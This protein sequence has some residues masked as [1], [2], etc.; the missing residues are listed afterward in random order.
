MKQTEPRKNLALILPD[1]ITLRNFVFSTFLQR[2]EELFAITIYH[3]PSAD[4]FAALPESLRAQIRF[5]QISTY[6][7]NPLAKAFRYAKQKASLKRNNSQNP[8]PT[9]LRNYPDYKKYPLHERLVF[10]LANFCALSTSAKW[11]YWLERA[12][13]TLF[14]FFHAKQIAAYARQFTA[15]Q[16]SVVLNAHQRDVKSLPMMRAAASKHIP[17]INFI[18]S[19]DNLPKGRMAVPASH[20]FVWSKYMK[21]EMNLYYPDIADKRI[22]I[23]GT[24]QFEFYH[25][26]V[27]HTKEQFAQTYSLDLSK[28]WIIYT[29]DMTDASPFDQ[30]YLEDVYSAWKNSR[31]YKQSQLLFRRAPTDLTGRFD[32]VLQRCP[33][34]VE[35]PTLWDTDGGHQMGLRVTK[36]DVQ[37][38]VDL[39]E[40]CHTAVNFGSTMAHDFAQRNKRIYYLNYNHQNVKKSIWSAEIFYSYVHFESLKGLDAVNWINHADQLPEIFS[41]DAGKSTDLLRWHQKITEPAER[42]AGNM[43]HALQSIANSA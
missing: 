27:P 9:F 26:F 33:E 24:P 30:H 34:I 2:A 12:Q 31:H 20:F 16:I 8:N 19:W 32:E 18:Y 13:I 7:E 37:L 36:E 23:T 17:Q 29:G 11:I 39:V 5:V 6:R 10:W 35:I 4:V 42:A 22:H 14:D 21:E 25:T 38:L 15:D 28:R 1:G 41:S 3:Y 43:V 40:H